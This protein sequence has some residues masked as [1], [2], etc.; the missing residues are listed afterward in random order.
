MEFSIPDQID[1][2]LYVEQL[3]NGAQKACVE[4]IELTKF[5]HFFSDILRKISE[6]DSL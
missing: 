6:P 2:K 3:E 1:I 4:S 5:I